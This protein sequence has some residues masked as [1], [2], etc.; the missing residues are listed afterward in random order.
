[1]ID[2]ATLP[3]REL[4]LSSL[5]LVQGDNTSVALIPDTSGNV[6]D[7]QAAGLQQGIFRSTGAALSPNGKPAIVF[8]G[9][10]SPNGDQ[11]FGNWDRG[12]GPIPTDIEGFTSY[13]TARWRPAVNAFGLNIIWQPASGARPRLIHQFSNVFVT[14]SDQDTD[15]G[16]HSALPLL[17]PTGL[18]VI[19]FRHTL[20]KGIGGGAVQMWQGGVTSGPNPNPWGWTAQ[21]ADQYLLSGNAGGNGCMTCDFYRGIIFSAVHT[22]KQRMGVERF[23]RTQFGF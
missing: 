3:H 22:E 15:F 13:W 20:P 10:D 17:S 18:A 23:L 16:N 6:R 2:P 9:L 14:V 11:M 19:T 8:D 4:D 5:S 1:M 12:G 21:P 7:A